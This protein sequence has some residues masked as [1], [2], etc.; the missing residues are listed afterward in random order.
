MAVHKKKKKERNMLG[1]TLIIQV[2]KVTGPLKSMLG[3]MAVNIFYLK[4]Y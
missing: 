1:V 3:L 2:F 4:I